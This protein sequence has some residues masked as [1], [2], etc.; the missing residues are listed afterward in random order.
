MRSATGARGRALVTGKSARAAGAAILTVTRT[1][2]E[3][4]SQALAH[5]GGSIFLQTVLA[6]FKRDGSRWWF[7]ESTEEVATYGKLSGT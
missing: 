4:D 1:S 6:R 7:L 3:L 5:E 2:G